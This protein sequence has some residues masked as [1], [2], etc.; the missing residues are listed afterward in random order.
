[1]KMFI[2]PDGMIRGGMEW[3]GLGKVSIFFVAGHQVHIANNIPGITLTLKI[4]Q[5]LYGKEY[6]IYP[7]KQGIE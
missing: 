7:E 3:G 4:I 1:M 2:E 6:S 5:A